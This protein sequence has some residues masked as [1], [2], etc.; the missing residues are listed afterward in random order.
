MNVFFDKQQLSF[1]LDDAECSVTLKQG[2]LTVK[3]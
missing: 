2:I 3:Q 1:Y